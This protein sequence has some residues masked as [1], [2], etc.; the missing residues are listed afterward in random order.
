[1][2]ERRFN[3]EQA[4]QYG[5]L[6]L[7]F[8]TAERENPEAAERIAAV[9][10]DLFKDP[11][12]KP[13]T[14]QSVKEGMADLPIGLSVFGDWFNDIAI[15]IKAEKTSPYLGF[16]V[17]LGWM[18]EA[19]KAAGK[20]SGKIPQ[21]PTFSKLIEG[22]NASLRKSMLK[23]IYRLSATVADSVY[24][25]L[26]PKDIVGGLLVESI[27]SGL[28]AN[29]S[30]LLREALNKPLQ[31]HF[32]WLR[33]T[34]GVP[35]VATQAGFTPKLQLNTFE[36]KHPV[37]T[38]GAEKKVVVAPEEGKEIVLTKE[39]AEFIKLL[40]IL[41][42]I[43]KKNLGPGDDDPLSI[44]LQTGRVFNSLPADSQIRRV[45]LASIVKQLGE[46]GDK[47]MQRKED[48]KNI[49]SIWGWRINVL[50]TKQLYPLK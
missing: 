14:K 8:S 42:N 5:K 23:E 10:T 31:G 21:L 33:E 37:A 50:F 39:E 46:D 24:M 38:K 19:K 47:L 2:S 41:E 26:S 28:S 13:V 16:S 17:K 48:E 18:D 9:F 43:E 11:S 3:P 20:V 36:Q 6:N 30:S 34:L 45:V 32:E 4:G 27:G 44:I 25:G 40:E 49:F 35:D 22:G 7:C 12:G 29:G 1:M 15:E